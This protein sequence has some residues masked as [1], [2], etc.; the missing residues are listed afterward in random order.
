[1]MCVEVSLGEKKKGMLFGHTLT[2]VFLFCVF[3]LEGVEFLEHFFKV[4]LQLVHLPV[5]LLDK[6]ITLAV[7][8]EVE[9]AEVILVRLNLV[10][11]NIL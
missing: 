1:M 10:H 2:C 5:K 3:L 4:R 7:L 6:V 9:E 8:S 11:E